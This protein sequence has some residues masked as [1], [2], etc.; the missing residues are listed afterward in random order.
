MAEFPFAI[1]GK[2][3]QAAFSCMRRTAQVAVPFTVTK[4]RPES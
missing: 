1:H 4:E 2:G 3:G